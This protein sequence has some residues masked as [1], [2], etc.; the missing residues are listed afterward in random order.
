MENGKKEQK[1]S[2]SN[3]EDWSMAERTECNVHTYT[4]KHTARGS[5]SEFK[6]TPASVSICTLMACNGV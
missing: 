1:N 5:E 6:L 3:W 4:Y 2:H